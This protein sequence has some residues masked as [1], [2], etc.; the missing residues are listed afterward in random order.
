MENIPILNHFPKKT[1]LSRLFRTLIVTII[2]SIIGLSFGAL[3]G[4][5]SLSDGTARGIL[6]FLSLMSGFSFFFF[7]LIN[8]II[9][10]VKLQKLQFDKN[11]ERRIYVLWQTL[12]NSV[13][14]L[15]VFLI[16]AIFY[17]LMGINS[18]LATK[19]TFFL[20]L[21]FGSQTLGYFL[22]N[23]VFWGFLFVFLYPLLSFLFLI[24]R[25]PR[26]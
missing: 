11:S 16:P 9:D 23:S 21:F 22:T 25:K 17:I 19:F 15:A 4:V 1:W 8:V 20:T 24:F 7:T 5:G 12:L 14:H 10:R 2:S 6:N 26:Q 13:C 3:F 18:A